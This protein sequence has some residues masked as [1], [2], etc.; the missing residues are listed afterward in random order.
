MSVCVIDD[1]A[2]KRLNNNTCSISY[3]EFTDGNIF[4]G[5]GLTHHLGGS[6]DAGLIK[7]VTCQ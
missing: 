2:G 4:S 1:L 3:K 5:N 7:T 6:V